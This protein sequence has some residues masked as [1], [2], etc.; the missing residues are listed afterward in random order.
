M[1]LTRDNSTVSNF[2]AIY[3]KIFYARQKHP[4]YTK[5]AKIA[6]LVLAFCR[7]S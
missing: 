1:S 7:P 5:K 4:H 3:E 2:A 6:P